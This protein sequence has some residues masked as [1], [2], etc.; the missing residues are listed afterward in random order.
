M[1]L[2]YKLPLLSFFEIVTFVIALLLQIPSVPSIQES[3]IKM[4]WGYPQ[5]F[6]C[7]FFLVSTLISWVRT[8][9]IIILL[10]VRVAVFMAFSFGLAMRFQLPLN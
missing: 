10:A 3:S 7:I 1:S 2:N 6:G 9:D 4:Q 8:H 5:I